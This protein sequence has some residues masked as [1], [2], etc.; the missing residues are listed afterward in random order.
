MRLKH[1]KKRN[2]AFVYE[3][4]VR[5]LTKSIVKK[6]NNR[7]KR[8]VSILSEFFNKSSILRQELDLYKSLYETTDLKR[9]TAEKLMFEAKMAYNKIDKKAVF[10]TQ[11]NMIKK[12]NK[13]L[14]PDVL[15]NFVPNYRNIATI[16]SIFN[17]PSPSKNKVL[18]EDRIVDNMSTKEIAEQD[19]MAPIDNLVYKTFVDKFNKQY[20]DTLAEGQ[21]RLL[22]CYIS[23]FADNGL[24]LKYF[25]NEEL[26]RLREK[27]TD[28]IASAEIADDEDLKQSMN[29]VL[30]LINSFKETKIDDSMVEDVLKIQKLAIEVSE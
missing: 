16:Y 11:T 12:I 23:S 5:E 6:N 28:S 26:G 2:T 14:S 25:L 19:N 18:L 3:A 21:K 4:L 15:N 13:I 9:H 10:S 29:E 8:V 30:D 20:S 17:A 22:S 24:E 27:L 7:K 1:N